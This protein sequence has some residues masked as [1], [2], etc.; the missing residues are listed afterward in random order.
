M[1]I[2][3]LKIE[4]FGKLVNKTYDLT[5]LT[6]VIG[7]NEA[8]KSTILA[9]IK[10]MLFGFE[11]ATTS[12]RNFNPLAVKTY[13][14]QINLTHD[15]K[16]IDIERLKILRSGK[17]SFSCQIDGKD[18]NEAEW[19]AFIKPMTATLF[20]EIYSVTQEN[21]QIAS[22]KDYNA[23]KL[24]AEWRL[25]ATTGSVILF[26]QIQ[27]L[28]KSR[29][30]LFTTTRA[31]KKPINQ[32][33]SEIDRLKADIAV[34][35][36]EESALL[37]LISENDQLKTQIETLR[38]EQEQ[39]DLALAD[40]KQKLSFLPEYQEYRAL[41]QK[42]S[43][44]MLTNDEADRLRD[45]HDKHEDYAREITSLTQKIAENQAALAKLAT[46]RNDFLKATETL[47]NLRQIKSDSAQALVA[48]QKIKQMQAPKR[49][50]F[51]AIASFA[52]ML[53][54]AVFVNPLVAMIFMVIGVVMSYLQLRSTRQTKL[55]LE[56]SQEILTA[57]EAELQYFSDWLAL[58]N[59]SLSEKLAGI[60]QLEDEA[61]T[62]QVTLARLDQGVD[63]AR[64]A[65]I[66]VF[67][68]AIFAETP[69]V[70]TAPE[71]LAKWVQ[72]SRDMQRLTR[73]KEQLSG[74]FDLSKPFDEVAAQVS[75]NQKTS[76]KIQRSSELTRL[77]D[78]HSQ[79][80]A[81]INQKKTDG[82]LLRLNAALARQKESLRDYLIAFTAQ[83]AQIT[84]TEQ[85]M[86]A[87]SSE[88]LPDILSRASD[89]LR[90]LTNGAWQEIYLD[91]D[92]LWVSNEEKQHLR[93]LD[94]STG[95]RDQLQFAL[96][97]AF[98]QSKK[99]DF[100]L[101]LDDNFLR[102]DKSRRKNFGQL[103]AEIAKN[104]QV[105]LLTSDPSLI[106]ENEGVI[107]L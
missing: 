20:D 75:L 52:L 74:I 22:V 36:A 61:Q 26:D 14:G 2:N 82:S 56:D 98:I 88:T 48:E 94:L 50:L 60:S 6:I 19:L 49:F 106:I 63:S 21:L 76:E 4:G 11:N 5:D 17:P 57:F 43:R 86:A 105:I 91:K 81:R 85:V 62:L 101:F 102:F 54:T 27:S 42:E 9:F 97:M 10:Y 64:L 1:K 65:E 58:G 24:D 51:V 69:D 104:R 44:N 100:P 73:L 78:T 18:T 77:I 71:L 67:D 83:S 30:A 40:T 96:R 7:E 92:I 25:S 16:S 46:P 84:L 31:S 3:Q 47:K 107:T 39:L 87:L 95:T 99:L 32:V 66:K 93:L 13:G 53:I 12:N 79:R 28:T 89:S 15:G 70:D 8:G 80:L 59:N 55:A 35:T 90:L 29:D 103:L 41:L 72:Q 23:E 45:N 68:E 37:P 38:D 33:L 34:K